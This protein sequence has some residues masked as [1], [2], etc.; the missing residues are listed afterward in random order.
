MT[1]GSIALFVVLLIAVGVVA[2]YVG[3]LTTRVRLSG[4]EKAA[5]KDAVKKSRAVLTG[6]F[7][8]QLAPY[9]PGFRY[10]P[11]ELRFVGKPVDYVVFEGLDERRIRRVIFLEI[12][13]G[14][15]T[16]N[17]AERSLRDAVKQGCVDFE[18][19]E[20][21]ACTSVANAPPPQRS[22]GLISWFASRP[23]P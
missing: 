5:R 1:T 9:L 16:L 13:S 6:N 10:R 2:Y 18:I 7:A 23:K 3:V 4:L 11:T 12:K 14:G 21:S 17:G 8:E 20:A 15:G 22:S 19:Y